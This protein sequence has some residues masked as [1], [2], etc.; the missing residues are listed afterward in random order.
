[1]K[2][3][4]PALTDTELVAVLLGTGVKGMPVN[5]VASELLDEGLKA[6]VQRT[7]MELATAKGLGPAK[8]T[9][10]AAALE[11]GRRV[12][13]CEDT[14]PRLRSPQEIYEYLK[15]ELAN[16]GKEVFH[17]LCLNSR[18][19]LLRD[20]RVAEGTV[21]SCP[22]DPRELF[23]AALQAKATAIV[24]AHNHPSGDPE[25]SSM[26]LSLT[27]QVIAGAN[28]LNLEVLDHLVIGDRKYVSFL[29]RG[30]LKQLTKLQ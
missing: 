17:I 8:A 30:L 3:G 29:E 22:V 6:L 19:T 20:V 26:D 9:Q 4:A 16:L 2:F 13:R 11:L 21:N 15:P 10:I 7:P 24:L 23:H 12:Q 5:E 25:P 18:N 14:R 1:M 27:R 28:L